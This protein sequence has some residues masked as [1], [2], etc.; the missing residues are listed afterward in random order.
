MVLNLV[1]SSDDNFSP[2]SGEPFGIEETKI[3][4]SIGRNPVREYTYKIKIEILR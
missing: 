2:T 4:N 3:D 1:G